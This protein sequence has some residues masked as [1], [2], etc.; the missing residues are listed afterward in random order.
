[1]LLFLVSLRLTKK[2]VTISD[3]LLSPVSFGFN[4]KGHYS[5]TMYSGPEEPVVFG[6]LTPEEQKKYNGV[7][8]DAFPVC[9]GTEQF[10]GIQEMFDGQEVTLEG[11]ITEPGVH[12]LFFLSC[13][14]VFSQYKAVVSYKFGNG[15]SWLDTRAMPGLIEQPVALAL[16]A[17]VL[18]GWCVNWICNR[19][20]KIYVHYLLTTMFILGVVS[21]AVRYGELKYEETYDF[22]VGM[23][24]AM[25][26]FRLLFRITIYFAIL[27][28]AKGWCIIQRS[29][30]IVE[31]ALAIVWTVGVLVLQTILEYASIGK[32]SIL[33]TV[34]AC[35]FL[36]LYVRALI[37]SINRAAL[38]IYARLLDYATSGIDPETTPIWQKK[39]MM[40]VLQYVIVTYFILV[41]AAWIVILFTATLPWVNPMMEDIADLMICVCLCVIYRLRN[42]QADGYA[43]ID[44]MESEM[45]ALADLDGLPRRGVLPKGGRKWETGMDIPCG[46]QPIEEN[47]IR[48]ETPDGETEIVVKPLQA[49]RTNDP[50]VEE[51]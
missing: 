14:P 46:P 38:V 48:L 28:C 18:V 7:V 16:F 29:I 30:K 8:I 47:V 45:V 13:M 6:I 27:M 49:E 31:L 20:M 25:A 44:E 19:G 39:H 42:G 1:M 9:N 2:E 32:W 24:A 4:S 15:A 23:Q 34:L 35:V 43:L 26:L 33:V 40:E 37:V 12:Y 51:V 22:H 11:T 21:R 3:G 36:C 5:V 17:C 50:V 41:L 10:A